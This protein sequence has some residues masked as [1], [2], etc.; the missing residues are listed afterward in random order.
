MSI[1]GS[2]EREVRVWRG[3]DRGPSGGGICR[4]TVIC[5][6]MVP[7][8]VLGTMEGANSEPQKPAAGHTCRE[9][10]GSAPVVAAVVR[11]T[12]RLEMGVRFETGG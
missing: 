7:C 9:R 8:S 10:R 5:C 11:V 12:V 3:K 1:T 2:S 6:P 4:E